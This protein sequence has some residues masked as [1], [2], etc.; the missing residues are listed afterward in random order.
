MKK[1][2][3]YLLYFL[4][5]CR[6]KK[7]WIKMFNRI[8]ASPVYPPHP[9]STP[10]GKSERETKNGIYT[11]YAVWNGFVLDNVFRSFLYGI[12]DSLHFMNPIHSL[13]LWR[14]HLC[15]F[16]L[17][18]IL[19]VVS[20]TSASRVS[21]FT[22]FRFLLSFLILFIF[23]LYFFIQLFTWFDSQRTHPDNLILNLKKKKHVT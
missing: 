16:I 3:S 7:R 4:W 8:V 5:I 18:V 6:R 13:Q 9:H 11:K 14:H 2:K 12:S 20:M 15:S 1:K 23:F 21:F 22:I 10:L 17:D 19:C